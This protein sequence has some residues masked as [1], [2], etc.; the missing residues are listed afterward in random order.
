MVLVCL[1]FKKRVLEKEE[2]EQGVKTAIN[3]NNVKVAT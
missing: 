2:K 3:V 1:D